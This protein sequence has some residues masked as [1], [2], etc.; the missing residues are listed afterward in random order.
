LID[1]LRERIPDPG[2]L[3]QVLLVDCTRFAF[4]DYEKS[5]FSTVLS[6]IAAMRPEFVNASMKSGIC[7]IDC[8]DGT[9]E[10]VAAGGSIFLDSGREVTLEE[11]G[12]VADGYWKQWKEHWER[13]K[14]KKDA[15]QWVPPAKLGTKQSPR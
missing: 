1:Y 3:I 4:K 7:E 2:T 14:I 11:L 8:V 15:E 13:A 10:V 6:D 9:F 5:E 12:V